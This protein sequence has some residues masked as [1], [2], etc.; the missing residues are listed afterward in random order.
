MLLQVFRFIAATDL[1]H[2]LIS[3]STVWRC[4][5]IKESWL[6]PFTGSNLYVGK[7]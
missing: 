4:L 2:F 7:P 1:I 6:G 3:N 5:R